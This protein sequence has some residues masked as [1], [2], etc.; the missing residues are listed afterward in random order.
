M[1]RT[2]FHAIVTLFYLM[3]IF[4]RFKDKP[5]LEAQKDD[6]D[7]PWSGKLP[8]LSDGSPIEVGWIMLEIGIWLDRRHQNYMMSGNI[9][10]VDGAWIAELFSDLAFVVALSVRI[11]MDVLA[12]KLKNDDECCWPTPC[13][14]E[15]K[16]YNDSLQLY[17]VYQV[18]IGFKCMQIAGQWFSFINNHEPLGILIIMI[19]QM[20]KD[21]ELFLYLF[22]VVTGAFMVAVTTEKR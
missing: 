4:V 6:P 18:I 11:G 9:A 12:N 22:S 3:I 10:L 14:E 21:V 15:C 13:D 5:W 16:P 2:I 7:V 1:I 17:Q 19:E 8:L 20:V